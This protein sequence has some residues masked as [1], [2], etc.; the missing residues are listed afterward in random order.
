MASE[1]PQVSSFVRLGIIIHLRI[2]EEYLAHSRPQGL[3]IDSDDWSCSY[4]L[5]LQYSLPPTAF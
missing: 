4:R 1:P 3:V 5:L 2:K